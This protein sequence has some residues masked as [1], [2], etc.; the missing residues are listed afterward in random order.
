MKKILIIIF[1]SC[2][3]LVYSQDVPQLE[4]Y[5]L[6]NGVKI[7]L[8]QYG[9]IPAVNVKFMINT[10]D[11]NE[12]PGQQGYSEITAGMLL[13]GNAKY[14]Q[15]GQN[16]IAFK[17]GGDLG[18]SAGK[19]YTTITAN[20]LSKDFDAGM[21]LF[22]A[23][24]LQPTFKK[25]KLDQSISYYID[26]NNPAKMDIAALADVFGDVFIYGT[27]NPLGRNYYKAQLKLITPEKIKEFHAFNYTPK[28]ASI[29]VCG[30]FNSTGIKT[31]IEKYF[32]AWQST[33][34]EVN[35]VSLDFP[36]IKKKEIA[37]INRSG[38]TQCALNWSKMA[39]SI[40]DKDIQA[41]NVANRIFN[42]TLFSEIRE[43]GGKTYSIGSQHEPSQFSNLFIVACSVRSDEMLNTINLFDKTLQNF[44]LA[45]IS[46]DDFDKA[47]KAIRVSL[48]SS[49]MPT[50][51]S[52]FYNP[53]VYDFNKRKNYLSDLATV[54][55]E[56][57][58]KVIKKY[59][60]ADSYKLVIAGDE[61]VVTTQLNSIKGLTKF[62]ASDIEKD[63]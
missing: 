1:S 41:F 16:D 11:K 35:G 32:G 12:A 48:M 62:K 8:M 28:N 60:T 26:Y 38:A 22:S 23:A 27:S 36:Q 57:V 44:N 59:F 40:K 46:Q 17:L 6:K 43:K 10:G 31:V 51:I 33:Y 63:N 42:T 9:K 13:Q 30:N 37:F 18:S 47:V 7:Y 4:T 20:F 14:T 49:E 50:A 24:I 15:E 61:G 56:D 29:I 55:I 19:D 58:Q 21:D 3:S 39:P 52:S 54:K 2:V 5:T 45:T 53:V 25:D 34:G